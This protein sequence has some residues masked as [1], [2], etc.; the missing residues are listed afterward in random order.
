MDDDTEMMRGEVEM[1]AEIRTASK[2][3]GEKRQREAR[4]EPVSSRDSGEMR[5]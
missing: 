1:E 5:S 2:D 3:G 4:L